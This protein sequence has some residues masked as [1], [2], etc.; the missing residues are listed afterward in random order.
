[1]GLMSGGGAAA[2]IGGI[3][4][5]DGAYCDESTSGMECNDGNDRRDL[6]AGSILM[7][8]GLTLFGLAYYFKPVKPAGSTTPM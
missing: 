3:I 6:I 8:A 7:V 5:V 2:F 1:M 4:A